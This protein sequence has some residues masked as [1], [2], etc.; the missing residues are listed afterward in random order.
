VI[1]Y[2]GGDRKTVHCS[3]GERAQEFKALI[4][5]F[6]GDGDKAGAAMLARDNKCPT[7]SDA[8]QHH[9][10]RLNTAPYTVEI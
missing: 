5:H 2:S 4:E 7:V 8:A 3:T 6:K 1:W 10:T 9:F